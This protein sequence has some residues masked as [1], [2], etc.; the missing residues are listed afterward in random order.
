M[1]NYCK[2]YCGVFCVNGTCPT[3]N[4][5]EYAERAIDVIMKCDDCFYYKG[6]EDCFFYKTD[7][8]IKE[9]TNNG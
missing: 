5:E 7:M 6:C 9:E 3:A 1:T 2:G 8:C 4:W